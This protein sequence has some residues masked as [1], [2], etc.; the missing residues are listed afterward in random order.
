MKAELVLIAVLAFGTACADPVKVMTNDESHNS[1]SKTESETRGDYLNL[2][3]DE[4][5]RD[6]VKI[7]QILSKPRSTLKV[8]VSNSE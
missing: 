2:I 1:I 7:M 5:V 6:Y 3:P 4:D 8:K